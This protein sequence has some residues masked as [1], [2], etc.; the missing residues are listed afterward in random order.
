MDRFTALKVFRH[1]VELGSFAEAS[2]R[3]SLSPAA[4]SKNISE[5]EAYLGVRL[6]HRTTRRMSL[7]ETGSFYYDRVA[8][9]LDDL[10]DADVTLTAMQKLPKGLLRVSAPMTVTLTCLSTEL[11]KFLNRYPDL[12]VDLQLDDRRVNI[13]EEGFDMALRG[14]DKLEDSSLVARKLIT[15][16]HVVCCASSY[17]QQF[18]A[19]QSPEDLARHNCVQFSLSDHATEWTF[20]TDN[21]TVTVPINSRYKVSSSLAVR[22]ALRSGFGLS[23]IP[24]IY[25]RE[26]LKAGRLQ[27]VLDDWSPN[28]TILY[29]VYPSRRYVVSKVR[30]FIDFLIEELSEESLSLTG[31]N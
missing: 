5:L 13:V 21:R 4:I 24:W 31:N 22:D 20:Q 17:L 19:P 8:R 2:R 11:P 29:A 16:K 30:A 10:D 6:M 1:V 12:S 14:S 7:T 3:L 18:G 28:E 26:D 15:M 25:V 23:L 27:T 9:V